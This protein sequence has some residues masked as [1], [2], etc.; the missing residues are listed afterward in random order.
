MP[1]THPHLAAGLLAGASLLAASAEARQARHADTVLELRQYT[2]HP[3]RRDALIELFEQ[4][5][6]EG[7]EAGGMAI[8]GQFRDLDDPDRFV[9]LRTFR[10]MPAR[11]RALNDFYFGPV[12]QAN[13]DAANT[14][15]VDSDNVLLLR[16]ALPGSALTPSEAERPP[17]GAKGDGPG[18]VVAEILYLRAPVDP[19]FLTFFQTEAAPELARAGAKVL[20]LYVTETAPNTFPQLPVRNGEQVVVWF[21]SYPDGTAYEQRRAVLRQSEAWRAVRGR[22]SLWSHQ[23]IQTLRLQPTAR[24]RLHG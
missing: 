18:L 22:L 14:T 3:G 23:P 9:W 11:A 2:L 1:K 20:G 21:T 6:V 16:P 8:P 5:F 12:W 13:R 10:D 15:M 7:Q 4:N 19:A 24:S 17:L